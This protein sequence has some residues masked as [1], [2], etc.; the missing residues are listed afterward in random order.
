M[1]APP[2]RDGEYVRRNGSTLTLAGQPFRFLGNNVYFN[3]AD[4]VYH[5]PVPIEET[6]DKM[7]ALGLTVA[8]C[9]AHNDNDPAKDPAAI[10]LAPG[11][12]NE[13]SL[14][15]LDQSIALARAR[16]IRLILKFTNYWEAYGGIR[17]Y[18]AWHLNRTPTPAETALFYTE[19][20]IQS[21]FFDYIRTII[22]RRNTVTGV[23]YRNEPA[24]LAWELAN[25][26]RNPGDADS[27]LRW[28]AETAAFIRQQ[29][30]NHL[31]AD[32]GEGFDDDRTLYT[33]L[34]N[35]YAVSGADGGSFHRLVE[36]P[37]IDMGSYHLY[38]TAWN[39]NDYADA[40][41]YIRRH[42]EIAARA[43]KVAYMGEFGKPAEDAPRAE[44]FKNWLQT[45]NL[46][47]LWHLIPDTKP[48]HENYHVYYP[49]HTATC[50]LLRAA[51]P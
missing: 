16:N 24:I 40:E 21:W 18:V 7:A 13:Q 22:D 32:G 38:P 36:I 39:M 15:A 50:D 27:L 11:V 10:Q 44:I 14:I 43:G 34:S 49:A 46:A 33:G 23:T 42:D 41:L 12:Y 35:R 47:L 28:T 19:P 4:I 51:A 30:A 29:D 2:I 3:Q 45:A 26:L 5:G 17:R 20:R 6:F 31:I 8:R 25:E 1:P 9:N 37:D 48:D